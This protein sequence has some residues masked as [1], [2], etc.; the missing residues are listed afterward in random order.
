MNN[1][2]V[3]SFESRRARINCMDDISIEIQKAKNYVAYVRRIGR[4]APTL[5]EKIQIRK[6][7]EEAQSVVMKLRR[8]Y[9]DIEDELVLKSGGRN[10]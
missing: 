9:F 2:K 7:L 1:L 10:G 3:P 6:K 4:K 5:E 8:S